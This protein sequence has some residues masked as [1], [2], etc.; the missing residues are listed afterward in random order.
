MWLGY[1]ALTDREKHQRSRS[2]GIYGRVWL[3][4]RIL[5]VAFATCWLQKKNSS[6]KV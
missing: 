6:K 1:V 2:C 5:E 4:R 3:A